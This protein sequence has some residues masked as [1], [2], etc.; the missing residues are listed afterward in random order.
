MPP[1]NTHLFGCDG[2]VQHFIFQLV[3]QLLASACHFQDAIVGLT[4]IARVPLFIRCQLEPRL[5][6]LEVQERLRDLV[7]F[8]LLKVSLSMELRVRQEE[9]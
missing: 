3:S 6:R 4:S 1:V 2:F 8:L 9:V 5:V 7:P